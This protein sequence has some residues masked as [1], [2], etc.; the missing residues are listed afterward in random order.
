MLTGEMDWGPGKSPRLGAGKRFEPP[1][2]LSLVSKNPLDSVWNSV[3]CIFQGSRPVA[4]LRV[5]QKSCAAVNH[6]FS[7]S[8]GWPGS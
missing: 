4:F 8:E 7:V 1:S 3:K 2:V 5:V 6:W